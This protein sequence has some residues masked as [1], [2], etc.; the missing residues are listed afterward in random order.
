MKSS[1]FGLKIQYYFK[2]FNEIS[3][4]LVNLVSKN[5]FDSFSPEGISSFFTFR[6]PIGNLT[7][8]KD[9]FKI[10]C[11]SELRNN[12]IKTYWYP[13]FTP[14]QITLDNAIKKIEELL[15]EAIK[16]LVEG[17]DKLGFAMSG[18]VD[19]SLIVALCRKIFP[20]RDLYTYS[21][22][23]YGEDEF[24]YSR[25]VAKELKTIHTEKILYKEDYVGKDSL[26]G[27]LIINKGEPLHPNE[28]ALGNIE[29]IAKNE[30][31]DIILCGE[32]ADDIFGGY[33]QNFR[34][35]MN[36]KYDIPFFKFFLDNYRYF[37]IEDKEYL[38]N[39][40][41]NIDDY[42]LLMNFLNENEL[43]ENIKNYIPYFTQKVHTIGLITRGI[44]A[45]RYN[46]FSPGF[47]FINMDLVNFVN[48]LPFKFKLKWKSKD[49]KQK[50]QGL[51]FRDISENLDIPKFILKKLAEKYL[52]NKIIYRPK[53]GF[54]VP[55][56]F[57]FEELK[58]WD[59]D[60]EIF[61]TNDISNLSGWKKFMIINLNAFFN[62][63]KKHRN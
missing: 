4:N 17:K 31:C 2:N 58:D 23:F 10:S 47:P 8:F 54:P 56:D 20:K 13:D 19:S 53:Y 15:I 30:G 9:Y 12:E 48:S 40:E 27:P 1:P 60:E 7:M 36:Y 44:N 28:L 29:K 26:L 32:G 34:M 16:K 25:L 59:L 21:A 3:D 14:I 5:G 50:A 45:M 41:Y 24:E 38:L 61:I 49:S 37:S 35:Y 6:F 22:G 42:R 43:P 11:G 39:K 55:F 52:P 18:G 57:W 33:G 62:E 51:N 63:F 46:G